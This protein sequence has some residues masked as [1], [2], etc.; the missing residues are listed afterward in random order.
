MPAREL[1]LSQIQITFDQFKNNFIRLC[2]ALDQL[3]EWS[4]QHF[5]LDVP[6]EYHELYHQLEAINPLINPSNPDA[7]GHTYPVEPFHVQ[8]AS[9]E[10]VSAREEAQMHNETAIDENASDGSETETK[11]CETTMDSTHGDVASFLFD[12]LLRDNVNVLTP[13]SQDHL[14]N[15]STNSIIENLLD[16]M[17]DHEALTDECNSTPNH[18]DIESLGPF[19]IQIRSGTNL[20]ESIGLNDAAIEDLHNTT[21]LG[22]PLKLADEPND[23]DASQ[24]LLYS[25]ETEPAISFAGIDPSN[26]SENES[27]VC[28]GSRS[29]DKRM[30]TT[31]V[32]V[33]LT[34]MA[35]M[36]SPAVDNMTIDEPENPDSDSVIEA[37]DAE[38]D[39]LMEDESSVS[40]E[41]TKE[42][43]VRKRSNEPINESV[44]F[45]YRKFSRQH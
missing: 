12:E 20:N 18:S 36:R 22:T 2:T 3:A 9:V 1:T 45:S 43:V 19:A 13:R 21:F 24:S 32:T 25:T 38:E 11:T 44:S 5:D 34:R 29:E 27:A 35:P 6:E 23:L 41:Q 28:L 4:D 10:P 31:R 42:R 14:Y 26:H 40:A 15:L 16:T 8:E 33:L 17:V 30:V 37:T 39:Q 7:N